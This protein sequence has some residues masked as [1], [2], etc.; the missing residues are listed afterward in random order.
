MPKL[1]T[2]DMTDICD[3]CNRKAICKRDQ[4]F[5]DLCSDCDNNR[6]YVCNMPTQVLHQGLYCSS[7]VDSIHYGVNIDDYV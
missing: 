1:H 6:C 3:R 2:I 7:C 4:T 5:G